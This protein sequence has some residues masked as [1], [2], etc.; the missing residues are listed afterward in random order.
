MNK[1]ATILIVDD[2]VDFHTVATAALE[3]AGYLVRSL[4]E[5]PVEQI[6]EVAIDCDIILLD[7]DLPGESGINIC[8]HIK[9]DPLCDMIPVI[10][11]TGN[12]DIDAICGESGADAWL[13]K[14]FSSAALLNEIERLLT[15]SENR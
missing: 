3:R 15:T 10:L 2:N 8:K 1:D 12:A 4:Y 14:P 5:G 11:I 9:S 7:V 13:V 6:C